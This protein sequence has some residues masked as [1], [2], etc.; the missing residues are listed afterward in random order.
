MVKTQVATHTSRSYNQIILTILLGKTCI[1]SLMESKTPRHMLPNQTMSTT[2]SS[3]TVIDVREVTSTRSYQNELGFQDGPYPSSAESIAHLDALKNGTEINTYGIHPHISSETIPFTS[4]SYPKPLDGGLEAWL[5]V[6]G[7]WC[8]FFTS[9]GW[10]T[11]VGVFQSYYQ[12]HPLSNYTPSA[13]AWIPSTEMSL[14]SFGGIAFGHLFDTYGPRYLLLTGSFMHVFGLMMTSFG[15]NYYQFFLA[16]SV[17]SAIGASAIFY[18]CVSSASTWFAKRRS[19]A[20]GIIS[21]GASVGG[22]IFP[23][24]VERLIPRIGFAWTMRT[25]AFLIFGLLILANFTVK[26]GRIHDSRFKRILPPLAPMIRPLREPPFLLLI[27]AMVSFSFG[28]FLPYNF[29]ILQAEGNGMSADLSN[30]LI[31]ILNAASLP[32]R[33]LPGILADRLGPLFTMAFTS[34]ICSVLVLAL[35]LPSQSNAA[36]ISFAALYGF[37]S[38]A[39]LSLG[40][41]LIAQLSSIEQIGVRTGTLYFFVAVAVL[42]GNPIGGALVAN[43]A[44]GSAFTSM[45]IFSGCIMALGTAFFVMVRVRLGRWVPNIA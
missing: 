43:D 12:R 24:M 21:S 44:A 18:A 35:W 28:N 14:I 40:P 8:A 41:S 19:T 22:V 4:T 2:A 6:F 13:V 11:C 32:G 29:L 23:I 36:I 26:S 17:C 33:I 27:F 37:F 25:V 42:L 30:Y 15:N 10:I 7:C 38:G 9:F 3:P 20:F 31:P 1:I 45:Q 34:L 39:Y 5:V 16:Q